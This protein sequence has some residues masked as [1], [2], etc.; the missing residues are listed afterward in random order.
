MLY[1]PIIS[2]YFT[3][4]YKNFGNN[5]HPNM[6][7]LHHIFKDQAPQLLA[8]WTWIQKVSE[9]RNFSIHASLLRGSRTSWNA[10]CHN[11]TMS[12][13]HCEICSNVFSNR[14]T[15][16]SKVLTSP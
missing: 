3:I 9:S 15:N 7:R 10:Q 5:L 8:G 11:V 16:S 4:T 13:L 1:N 6:A 14:F 2:K 12:S